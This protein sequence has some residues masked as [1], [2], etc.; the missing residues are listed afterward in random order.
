MHEGSNTI[1]SIA[2]TNKTITI[3][4]ISFD[5]ELPVNFTEPLGASKGLIIL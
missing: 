2:I 1:V 5:P 3:S 4:R